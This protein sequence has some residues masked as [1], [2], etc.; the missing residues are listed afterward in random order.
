LRIAPPVGPPSTKISLSGSGF[1]AQEAVD[2]YFDTRDEALAA[3]DARGSFSAIKISVP[4]SAALGTHWVTAVGRRT[5]RAAQTRFLVRTDW[6][7]F[8]FNPS[9]SRYNPFEHV[10]GPSNVAGLVRAWFFKSNAGVDAS[11]AVAGGVVYIGAT[12]PGAMNALDASTGHR[13]W[14]HSVGQPNYGSAGTESS[15]AVAG[16]VVYVGADDGYT[17]A[18]DASTGHELW[19]YNTREGVPA[20]SS[21]VVARGVVYIGGSGL[22]ALDA[23]TGHKLW[24]YNTPTDDAV[25]SSPVVANGVVYFVSYDGKL[26]ALRASTGHK[27]WSYNTGSALSTSPAVA[28]G[29]VYVGSDFDPGVGRMYALDASTG[30]K[31]WS[32]AVGGVETAPAVADGVVYAGSLDGN[33]YALDEATGQELWSF[34]TGRYVNGSSPAVANGV[35]YIASSNGNFY[36]LDAST[37]QKLWSF[38]NR[39]YGFSSPAVA[40]GKVYIAAGDGLYAFELGVNL[41]HNA[42][43]PRPKASRLK[44]NRSLR[45]SKGSP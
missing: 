13:L 22:Y 14:Y 5:R 36:A 37:G 43:P 24:H 11:P 26:Y 45:P 16:G 35:V 3:T 7:Q 27:L 34:A 38:T 32:S 42:A 9:H 41:A 2:I 6:A 10:L 17:Y 12:A 30:Q 18:L 44:P 19:S 8:G 28:N 20:S 39:L 21:P 23:S 29:A 15:P 31:R 33:V 40:N 1:G 4:A 25:Y